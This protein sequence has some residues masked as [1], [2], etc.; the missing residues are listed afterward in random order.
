VYYPALDDRHALYVHAKVMVVDDRL[1]RIG[2]A[3][4]SNRSMGLDSECDL[5]LEAR[6]DPRV[7]EA[8][9]AFRNRLLGEHLGKGPQDMAAALEKEG[10]LIRAIEALSGSGRTLKP[11][12][13]GQA[14]VRGDPSSAI[15]LLDPE[16][17]LPFD[18]LIDQFVREEDRRP[19]HKGHLV[20][21]LVGLL[22]LLGL[23]AAWRWTTLSEWVDMR[24]MVTWIRAMD[25]S[26]LTPLGIVAGYIVGGV[27]MVPITLLIGATAIVFPL[28]LGFPYA[29]GGCLANALVT[30][31]VGT[32]LGR[33]IIRRVAGRRLNALSKRLAKQGLL[34]VAVV[35]NLPVAP[36]TIVNVV[37]GASRIRLRDFLLGTAVGMAPGIL[38]IMLFTDRLLNA[39]KDPNWVNIAVASAMAVIL[40][41]GIWWTKRRLSR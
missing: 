34:S 29:L 1:L 14:G 28:H 20:K 13:V 23:A 18:R 36:F 5:A 12:D 39:V 35:R 21:P 25:G 22:I 7:G 37:A 26:T 27:F 19:A 10:S 31:G 41:I 4:M 15:S 40:G 3:N 17:P 32:W 2:S 9:T 16:E 11:L 30:Y 6:D 24:Q 8:V 33:D 38:A